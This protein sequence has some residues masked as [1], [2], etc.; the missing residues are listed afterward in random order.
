M[1]TG[2]DGLGFSELPRQKNASTYL[3]IKAVTN[4]TIGGRQLATT[5]QTFVVRSLIMTNNG[6]L[7]LNSYGRQDA[8]LKCWCAISY[9]RHYQF[10]GKDDL[11]I[12]FRP[13]SMSATAIVS[14]GCAR[15]APSE[16]GIL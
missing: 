16:V 9:I 8:E 13:A 7:L 11:R 12:R 4:K 15:N 6:T 1:E 14:R 5:K 2:F 10:F 3:S